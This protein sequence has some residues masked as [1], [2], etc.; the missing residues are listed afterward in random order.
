MESPI[1][2]S[3]RS[4]TSFPQQLQK[5]RFSRKSLS[6]CKCGATAESPSYRPLISDVLGGLDYN[7]WSLHRGLPPLCG[8]GACRCSKHRRAPLFT[9]SFFSPV[10]YWR[11]L[12]EVSQCRDP[13]QSRTVTPPTFC[14]GGESS[15]SA[16]MCRCR[17]M[18]ETHNF[19]AAS[20][21]E[22]PS[23][24]YRPVSCFN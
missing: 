12:F 13:V 16:A 15:V 20:R 18:S 19:V 24:M 2:G 7:S 1:S 3:V 21:I 23:L 11:E 9:L 22:K 5:P 8:L 4:G 14:N 6:R 17:V 10:L